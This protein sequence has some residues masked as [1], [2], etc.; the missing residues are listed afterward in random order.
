MI[1]CLACGQSTRM[2]SNLAIA[3]ELARI[4]GY[5]RPDHGPGCPD[6]TCESHGLDH[7]A[8]P[9]LYRRNGFTRAGALRLQCRACRK[10][11]SVDGKPTR[12]HKK[13]HENRT[14]FA[15]LVN[16]MSL[17]RITKIAGLS[18]SALYG[19]IDFLH[20]Q[21]LGFAA[22]RERRLMEMRFER[23]YLATDRQD[24]YTNWVSRLR[25]QNVRLS[26]VGT[27]DLD[28]GYVFG[29]HLN[30]DPAPSH[31]EIEKYVIDHGEAALQPP[32]R[33]HA[34]I[35]LHAELKEAKTRSRKA[36][37]ASWP[38][39]GSMP[40]RIED[41]YLAAEAMGREEF[42]E[43][44]RGLPH[45]GIELHQEY[46]AAAHFQLLRWLL[47]RVGKL[48]FFIDQDSDLRSG[49]FGAFA[50][51]IQDRSCDVFYVR[52]AKERT[53]DQK[54][55]LV[56]A[57]R[58][59]FNQVKERFPG[60]DEG[61]IKL[62]LVAGRLAIMRQLGPWNDK[63][64]EHPLPTMAEPEKAIAHLTDY[65]DFDDVH[66]AW[67]F[68]RASLHPI[69]RFFMQLRRGLRMVERPITSARNANRTWNG[70]S[71][72]NPERILKLIEIYRTVFNYVETGEDG[73]TPAMRL[74]L[75][76]GRIRLEDI[77]YFEG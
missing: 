47:A 54:R 8:H 58:T 25:R 74:G 59:R 60:V 70:Y 61:G 51:R 66:A 42:V 41:E 26:A 68:L 71:A 27:A 1:C 33:R 21:C 65:G 75:A 38:I 50:D 15:L 49:C 31:A 56:A 16:G 6:A 10:T 17:R 43:E 19:K 32:F 64:L 3:E 4:G 30:Y 73:R 52:I 69:D 36:T 37:A 34:R 22:A 13:P 40:Q 7:R 46:T 28:S 29:L 45:R 53:I 12:K 35:W 63:W 57:A 11:F 14:V 23:L 76:Q 5:L 72:Y 24:Y 55:E 62:A 44:H 67:L 39:G 77:V 20:R 48:R 18:M 2:K 9:S